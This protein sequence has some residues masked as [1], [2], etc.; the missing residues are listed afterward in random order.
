MGLL[1]FHLAVIAWVLPDRPFKDER[2]L[3]REALRFRDTMWQHPSEVLGSMEEVYPPLVFVVWGALLR[4]SESIYPL[5]VAN[6]VAS[7]LTV[8]LLLRVLI[9]VSNCRTATALTL[10]YLL[11][12]YFHLVSTAFYTD[13]IYLLLVALGLWCAEHISRMACAFGAA[14]L[15]RQF[16]LIFLAGFGL[17]AVLRKP[18]RWKQAVLAP[19]AAL[20]LLMLMLYWGGAVASPIDQARIQETRE[21]TGYI[22]PDYLFYYFGSLGVYLAPVWSW[23]IYRAGNGVLAKWVLASALIPA[24]GVLIFPATE[25]HFLQIQSLGYV[26]LVFAA[27]PLGQFGLAAFAGLFGAALALI[28]GMQRNPQWIYTVGAFLFLQSFNQQCWDKYILDI[29]LVLLL[30]AATDLTHR[31]TGD[32]IAAVPPD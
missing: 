22:H 6:A 9:R 16:G 3:Y 1:T 24:L 30:M 25:N 12:P 11:N 14:S 19:L 5:R 27:V 8:F 23:V 15:A 26:S 2:L 28:A 31:K 7:A 20:P 10:A 17:Q 21:Q 13:A 32:A 18:F 4:V 29:S